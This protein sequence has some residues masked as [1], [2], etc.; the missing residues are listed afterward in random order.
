MM[1]A[2]F[3]DFSQIGTAT[4]CEWIFQ[5]ESQISNEKKIEESPQLITKKYVCLS[6]LDNQR[7]FHC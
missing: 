4:I 1:S 7:Q 2:Y 5:L 6:F 3:P